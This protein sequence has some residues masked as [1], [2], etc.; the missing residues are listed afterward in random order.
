M[1]DFLSNP[2]ER[3]S[4]FG[5]P[6]RN[7]QKKS[8]AE[9]PKSTNMS[10]Q[11][12]KNNLHSPVPMIEEKCKDNRGQYTFSVKLNKELEAFIRAALLNILQSTGEKVTIQQ[13]VN[14]SVKEYLKHYEKK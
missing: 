11:K 13:F 14:D 5:N 6:V 12:K 3:I 9:E 4:S 2:E 10:H 1:D 8:V 7:T